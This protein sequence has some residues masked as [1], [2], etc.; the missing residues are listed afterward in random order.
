M[1]QINLKVVII[2][3]FIYQTSSAYII[4]SLIKII[5]YMRKKQIFTDIGILSK[6]YQIPYPFFAAHFIDGSGNNNDAVND[7]RII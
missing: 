3:N 7:V 6:G 4:L 5:Y 1:H 2:S